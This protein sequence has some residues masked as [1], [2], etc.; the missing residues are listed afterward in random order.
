MMHEI[1]FAGKLNTFRNSKSE[2][3]SADLHNFP[4][5]NKPQAYHWKRHVISYPMPFDAALYLSLVWPKL[6]QLYDKTAQNSSILEISDHQYL[7]TIPCRALITD[8][9]TYIHYA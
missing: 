1:Y 9:D 2:V 7:K 5:T 4:H 8:T 3:K 6:W